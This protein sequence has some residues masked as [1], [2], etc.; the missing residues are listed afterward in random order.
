MYDL[1]RVVNVVGV[2][3]VVWWMSERDT[4]RSCSAYSKT[5]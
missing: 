4:K 2:V 5:M 1:L 3:G